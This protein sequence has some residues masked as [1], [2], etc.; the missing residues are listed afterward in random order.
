M[1][2]TETRIPKKCLLV[3][4]L[5]LIVFGILPEF[6]TDS[7]LYAE[8]V[9]IDIADGS[10]TINATD[11]TQN[12]V[13][14]PHTG[15][16]VITGSSTTNNVNINAGTYDITLNGLNIDVS[17]IGAP[18]YP[19]AIYLYSGASVNLTLINENT[20]RSGNYRP[21]LTVPAGASLIITTESSGSLTSNGGY[22]AAGIGGTWGGTSGNITINGGTVNATGN[23]GSAGIGGGEDGSG[24]TTT[25]NGGIVNATGN[26]GGAGIGGGRKKDQYRTLYGGT[27]T[28]NGGT[29]TAAG[30]T[31]SYGP[32]GNGIGNGANNSGSTIIING[33]TVVASSISHTPKNSL[34]E[35]V[36]KTTLTLLNGGG[37]SAVGGLI[38]Q[39]DGVNYNYGSDDVYSNN[40]GNL[41]F[42][43]PQKTVETNIAFTAGAVNYTYTLPTNSSGGTATRTAPVLNGI[44]IT[45]PAAKLVYSVNEA[46]DLS[47]MVVTGTYSDGVERVIPNST[48]NVSGF[49]SRWPIASQTLTVEFDNKTTTY[50]V[51]IV[52]PEIDITGN[53]VSI[54]DGDAT[55][56]L[57]DHTDF[58]STDVLSGTV[59]R[60]FT[61]QN[62]GTK[63]LTLTG[64]PKV[65]VGGTNATDFTVTAQPAG[66]VATAGSTTFQVTFNPSA[67]GL[68]TATVSIAN[69]DPDENPYNFTVQ[70]TGTAPEMNVL[71]NGANIADGATV[72]SAGNHTDFGSTDILAGTVV[73]TFTIENLGTYALT[74]SGRPKVVIS[75]T[76]AADFTVTAEPA[77]TVAAAGST[78]FQVT[79]DP[80]AIGQRTATVSIAN[81]D[82]DENPYNFA[83][84]GAGTVSPE[85]D[86]KGNGL[87][88]ADGDATPDLADHTDFD[89]VN[90]T[91]G[92]ITRTFTIENSGSGDL[93][94]G[95]TPI[96]ALSGANATDFTVTAEPSGTVA[97]AVSTTFQITFDPSAAGLRMATISIANDDSD[98]NPYNFTIQGTGTVAPEINVKGNNSGIADGDITPASSDHTDFGYVYV[99]NGAGERTFT[100]ENLGDGELTLSGTPIV[101]ITGTDSADFT[102]VTMPANPVVA[103]GSTTLVIRFDPSAGGIRTAEISIINDDS[104]ENPYTF[105][106]Q[107]TGTYPDSGGGG[108]GGSGQPVSG[109]QFTSSQITEMLNSGQSIEIKSGSLSVSIEPAAIPHE[110]NQNIS[111][112]ASEVNDVN[113]LNAF[114]ISFPDQKGIGRGFSITMSR[115]ENGLTEPVTQLNGEITLQF[116][117]TPEEINGLDPTTLVVYKQGDD[118]STSELGGEFDWKTGTLS[119]STSHLCKFFIMGK[120]GIPTERLAGGNRYATA[121]AIS[122]KGWTTADCVILTS[123]EN[124]PDALA[125]TVLAS[126]KNAPILLSERKELSKETQA[127]IARLKAKKIF[128]LGG[129]SVI[130]QEA[131]DRLAKDY[132]VTRISG[133]DRYETAV[134]LG[135]IV[136]QEAGVKTVDT[137]ILATGA[138]Y[139][140]ALAIAPYAGNHTIPVLFTNGQTFNK[141]VID[142]LQE[143]KTQK[144]LLAGGTG[145]ISTEVENILKEEMKLTVTRLSGK[146]R[147]LT[148]LAIAEYFEKYKQ[149][150]TSSETSALIK[151]SLATGENFPDALAGAALAAKEKMPLLL[152][153]K[154]GVSTEILYYLKAKSLEKLYVYGGEGVITDRT[155]ESISLKK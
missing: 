67:A 31:Y 116:K 104:D 54:A 115:Q 50:T 113:T 69:D 59:V 152:A 7:R 107:G 143:W 118:G 92:T 41:Y 135:K 138:N 40:E 155:K 111:I 103:G 65:V 147:Y 45:H 76:N 37:N 99:D 46:L 89:S 5:T 82:T 93:T 25:I 130:A 12:E 96:V 101:A 121:A 128:I 114:F 23:S 38:V 56:G 35:N 14:Y 71:G 145:V 77:G 85:I 63:T 120:E 29:V 13:T 110:N 52:A 100:I 87:S 88:I 141:N 122:Q 26:Y 72:P 109:N 4:A 53:E 137:V 127:E 146:D 51:A 134:K 34:N 102:V 22:L 133:S 57:T 98:E 62:S 9:S 131:E 78:T 83:I 20:L 43:L 15:D 140:D 18:S 108:S 94:L 139:P 10:V 132:S 55:P 151:A 66:T 30:V 74:L 90:I 33:G 129:T 106:I 24:G 73:R 68:R 125:G 149:E 28:I 154:D 42:Y 39:H 58:G 124:F 119:V 32:I 95:G 48:L 1:K 44:A 2:L 81:D 79:F 60:T 27:I 150:G 97:A 123:G 117:L 75:G 148:S 17:S 47:G 142:T 21:G 64:T 126:V 61:I 70:G 49:D 153:K 105:M 91:S 16:L 19:G 8:P 112:Q 36:Y 6:Y 84:Q 136:L 144:V 86:V 11:Y 80:S 3:L